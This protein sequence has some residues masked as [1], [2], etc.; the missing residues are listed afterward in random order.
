M[1]LILEQNQVLGIVEG[2]NE[3]PT[4]PSGMGAASKE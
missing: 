1:A 2:Y 3:K 4:G